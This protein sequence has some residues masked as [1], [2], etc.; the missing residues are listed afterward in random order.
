[1]DVGICNVLKFFIYLF[2]FLKQQHTAL[3][4]NKKRIASFKSVDYCTLYQQLQ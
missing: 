2:I 3:K 4:K 1:M